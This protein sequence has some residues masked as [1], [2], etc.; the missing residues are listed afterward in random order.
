MKRIYATEGQEALLPVITVATVTYNAF[1]TL[2]KTLDSVASQCYPNIEHLIV[3]G[4]SADHTLALIQE[5][6]NDNTTASTPHNIRL[7]CEPDKGLYDAMNKALTLA[8][9][10]YIVFLNAGDTFPESTTIEKLVN[11]CDIRHHDPANPGILYGETDLVNAHGQFLRHRRL[12]APQQLNWGDFRWGMMV[13]HQAFYVRC[14]IARSIPYDLQ[15]RF[16][17]DFDWCIRIIKYIQKRRISIVNARFVLCNYLSEGMTTQNQ[18][19]SLIERFR[20]MRQHYGLI[21]TLF[22]HL[23]FILRAFI[24]R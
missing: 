15:Y 7:M 16:S 1:N 20:I 17:S 12:Q 5:Y 11:T 23:W 21:S 10:D 24:R 2:Q 3:D 18:K 22:C 14:D 13:C 4:R 6:V 9:G 8:T 19:A